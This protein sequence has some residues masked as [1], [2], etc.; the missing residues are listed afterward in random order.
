MELGPEL[1]KSALSRYINGVDLHY[2][3]ALGDTPVAC[4]LYG[5]LSKK[6]GNPLDMKL[7]RAFGR[8]GFDFSEDMISLALKLG[9]QITR[10]SVVKTQLGRALKILTV[11]LAA[12]QGDFQYRFLESWD[13]SS[14]PPKI[15][16]KFA[17]QS[18]TPAFPPAR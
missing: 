6:D 10:P 7:A 15:F 13:I 5:Y 1:R 8:A 4:K 11:P 12:P 2:L 14:T 17:R 3:N 16:V 9:M 18:E